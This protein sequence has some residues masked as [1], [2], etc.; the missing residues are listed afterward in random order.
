MLIEVISVGSL[1][2]LIG[3]GIWWLSQKRGWNIPPQVAVAI[4]TVIGWVAGRAFG[5]YS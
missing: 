1:G 4:G 3:L 2:T 5:W